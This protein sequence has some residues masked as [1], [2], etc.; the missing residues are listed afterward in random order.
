MFTID[1]LVSKMPNHPYKIVLQNDANMDPDYLPYI[2][3]SVDEF[4][5]SDLYNQIAD[6]E[7]TDVYSENDGTI[8]IGYC[9]ELEEITKHMDADMEEHWGDAYLL[10]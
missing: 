9:F 1:D 5:G 8:W 4:L 10:D 7:V 3:T 6:L 2:F